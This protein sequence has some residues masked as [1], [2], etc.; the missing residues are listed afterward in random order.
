MFLVLQLQELRLEANKDKDVFV[1][2][3]C[4]AVHL[5]IAWNHH[6][7][8]VRCLQQR[9]PMSVTMELFHPLHWA[10]PVGLMLELGQQSLQAA[11]CFV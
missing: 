8:V 4:S 6:A 9:L 7:L 10:D 1:T 5:N 3:R 11:S 2:V